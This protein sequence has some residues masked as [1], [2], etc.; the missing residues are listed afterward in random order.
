MSHLE[1]YLRYIHEFSKIETT[2]TSLV[3]QRYSILKQLAQISNEV[4]DLKKFEK[5]GPRLLLTLRD[6]AIRIVKALC[7]FS[8]WRNPNY[9]NH[10]LLIDQDRNENN[11]NLD[12]VELPEEL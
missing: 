4:K 9:V 1:E 12:I 7:R 5:E 10:L 2:I 8:Q 6:L 11:N 3:S